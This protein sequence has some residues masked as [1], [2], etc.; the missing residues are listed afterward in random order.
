VPSAWSTTFLRLAKKSKFKYVA[1]IVSLKDDISKMRSK[2]DRGYH[3]IVVFGDVQQK[4]SWFY[5]PPMK[6]FGNNNF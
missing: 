5:D 1:A 3:W 2:H 6:Q 4:V